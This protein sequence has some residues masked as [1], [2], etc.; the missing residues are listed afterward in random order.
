MNT[1]RLGRA[2]FVSKP[3]YFEK[4]AG[5]QHDNAGLEKVNSCRQ[6]DPVESSEGLNMDARQGLPHY[7]LIV[8][9]GESGPHL[10]TM[11]TTRGH[12]GVRTFRRMQPIQREICS[13][14]L[15]F[16]GYF[17]E[18]IRG[19]FA[20]MAAMVLAA[21]QL[22]GFWVDG[23][24]LAVGPVAVLDAERIAHLAEGSKG[25]GSE[26]RF[27]EELVGLVLVV[28]PRRVHGLLNIKTALGSG[29]ED[30]GDGGDDARPAW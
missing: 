4:A 5:F 15:R 7:D 20:V 14:P 30:V 6:A 8:R 13:I 2:G 3:A 29:E 24:A 22:A 25:V 1:W 18:S 28:E 11:H 19:G 10:L 9:D 17:W 26:A 27:Q 23:D 12:I 16:E 21:S